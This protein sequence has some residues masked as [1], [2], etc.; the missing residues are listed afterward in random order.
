[1]RE[2]SGSLSCASS[3]SATTTAGEDMAS[4]L[5]AKANTLDLSMRSSHVACRLSSNDEEMALAPSSSPSPPCADEDGSEWR[6]L[7][8]CL[9]ASLKAF[10][11]GASLRGGL[12][13]FST[14]A[15]FRKR[16][17]KG[18]AQQT[19][20]L[21]KSVLKEAMRYGLFLGA[22]AGT[23]STVD[24]VISALGGFQRTAGWRALVAGAM[25]GPSLLLTGPDVQ[26]TSMAIYILLRAA[27]LAS[28]CGIKS[29]HFGWLFHPLAWQHGDAALM[30]LS[31]SQILSAWILK[32]DSLP[33]SYIS[34][35]NKHGGK[36]TSIVKCLKELAFSNQLTHLNEVRNF[37]KTMDVDV[38]LDPNMSIPCSMVHGSQ[39]CLSH[40][41][42][43]LGQAYQR[44]LPVYVPVYLIPAIIVHRQAIL[45]NP[46]PIFSKTLLGMARSSLFLSTYCASA[47]FWTCM[48]FRASRRCDPAMIA[49]GTFPTGLA[50][51]IEK[52]SRRMEIALYC[53]A[54]ALESFA[55]CFSDGDTILSKCKSKAPKRLDVLLFSIA[56][57]IIMHCYA[58]EREVFRSKYLNVLDWIFGIPNDPPIL[59]PPLVKGFKVKRVI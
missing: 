28:R 19:S 4:H 52:K 6:A 47:W 15:S 1:M 16:R 54:R 48:L 40:F 53:F 5:H 18:S 51:L 11:V 32:P 36:D 22:F 44:S 20:Q 27:V 43:F 14:L 30:C 35:L 34:F 39:G 2:M 3:S 58:Q 59:Q 23:F 41:F 26:H 17:S 8:R 12:S 38:Q 7:E 55:I 46:L 29:E 33:S 56:T 45:K 42:W 37:Y 50:V 31:S 21:L 13:L 24:E 9:T 10:A 57:S 25:A 49:L